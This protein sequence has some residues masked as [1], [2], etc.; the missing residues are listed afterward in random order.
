MAFCNSVDRA[1]ETMTPRVVHDRSQVEYEH[2]L[3]SE[4]EPDFDQS[5]LTT[6]KNF[7]KIFFFK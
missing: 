7:I 4:F 3:I 5:F 1:L 2:Y 6:M